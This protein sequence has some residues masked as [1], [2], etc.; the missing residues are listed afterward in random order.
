M[1]YDKSDRLPTMRHID[2]GLGVFRRE[3]LDGFPRDKVLDLATVQKALLERNELAGFEIA[4]RFY[5]IGSH[6]GLKE[7]DRLLKNPA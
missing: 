1:A 6:A 2:Y 3:A 7:L 4:E 5:E